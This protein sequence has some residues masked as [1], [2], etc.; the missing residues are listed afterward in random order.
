M[1]NGYGKLKLPVSKS[2]AAEDPVTT[3]LRLFKNCVT[4]L[5]SNFVAFRLA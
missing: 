5:G 3:T 1:E 2:F 4:D